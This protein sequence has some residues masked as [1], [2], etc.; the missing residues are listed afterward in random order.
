LV[1]QVSDGKE[2]E[3]ETTGA[4]IPAEHYQFEL[5]PGYVQLQRRMAVAHRLK[6]R[7]P[8]F[9]AHDGV[10]GARTE[11][12]GRHYINFSS[13]NYLGLAGHPQVSRA[14]TE[15]IERYGT[16]ASASRL[17]AGELPVHQELEQELAGLVGAE[18]C[19]A[20][21]SGH[22]TNV[23]TI[24][25]LFGPKDLILYDALIH[26]SVR[27]GSQLSG[28]R[29]ATFPHNDWE[30]LEEILRQQRGQFER[31][32]IVL[33]GVYSMDGDIPDLPRF[34]EIKK[35][36]RTFLMVDEAHSLGVLGQTGRG[37]GELFGV[38]RR[39]VDLWMGT[40]SKSFASCGGFIAGCK[41]VIGYLR[42]AAPGFVFSVGM[43]PPDA[44]A[45]LAAVR[46][47]NA[48]PERVTR[49][50]ERAALFLRLAREA[51]LDTSTS[52]GAAIVPVV[53]R[54]SM[55][56]LALSQ[57]L[58]AR[59]INVSPILHP[60]VVE[61]EARLRFFFSCDHTQEQIRE[62]AGAAAEEFSRL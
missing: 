10:A 16:S 59:G 38:D 47:L 54:D 41:E 57:A 3:A 25:Q 28:A 22:A 13:Y 40:L 61:R 53:V 29:W 7:V 19:L 58:F 12:D 9:V 11:I 44:A 56:T 43:S 1:G 37:T 62:A 55:K 6:L 34:I 24:G 42:Y 36:H 48:E 32:L 27:Q 35:R 23:T 14:A 17:V 30:K 60:G 2:Q 5:L 51:G 33:E 8:Y 4:D 18:S 21:V 26:N 45:A 20:F 50:R 15:A 39:D 49:L 52:D 46:L 31:V